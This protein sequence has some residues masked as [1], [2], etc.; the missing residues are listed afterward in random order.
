MTESPPRVRA[1]ARVGAAAPIRSD[2]ATL[3]PRR[4]P[5]HLGPVHIMQL[6]LAE[7]AIVAV[8]ATIGHGLMIMAVAGVGALVLLAVALARRQGRWWLER[9]VMTYRYRQRRRARPTGHRADARLTALRTLAPGLAIEDIGAP[10]GA[11]VGVARDDAGW[12][13]VAAITPSAA[14]RDDPTAGLPLDA[15]LTTLAEAGQP[16]V[17]LQI[18]THTVPAPGLAVDPGSPA[19]QSYRELLAQFGG[20]PVPVDRATWVAVRLDARALA[21][22]GADDVAEVDQAPLLIA[23]LVRRVAKSLR[24]VGVPYQVLDAEGL[25]AALA[26]SCDLAPHVE[27]GQPATTQESWS[28]WQS[29]QLTHRTFWL[30]E[31]PPLTE[32]GALLAALTTAQAALTSVSLVLAAENEEAPVDLRCLV[33]VAAP[34]TALAVVCRN[35][36]RGAEQYRGQLFP[37]DGEQGPGTYATAPTGGGP[38]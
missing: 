3:L 38:R 6:L 16:G 8:V 29:G 27:T 11:Q 24:H 10:D 37:L 18:V 23:A 31:W 9:R 19:G 36:V 14:M 26:R 25:V 20:A 33:R 5:G 1:T 34:A 4:R 12:Y 17:A 7:A 28:V 13:A 15:L 30:R 2:A 32:A 22:A 21:E 35:L